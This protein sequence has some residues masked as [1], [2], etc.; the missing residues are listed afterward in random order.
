MELSGQFALAELVDLELAYLVG[1]LVLSHPVELVELQLPV[2]SPVSVSALV[3]AMVQALVQAIV[4]ALD[5]PV[6]PL[7]L[8]QGLVQVEGSPS[9]H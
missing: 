7:V 4:L 1:E 9:W 6:V 2:V 8:D 5:S 3:Q